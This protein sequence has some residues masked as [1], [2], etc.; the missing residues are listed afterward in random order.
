MWEAS[1]HTA[2]WS[3]I[4]V[5]CIPPREKGVEDDLATHVDLCWKYVLA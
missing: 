4:A 1:L 2:A 3:V 5:E